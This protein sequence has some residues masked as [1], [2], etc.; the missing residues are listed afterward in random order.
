M[1]YQWIA[2]VECSSIVDAGWFWRVL[3]EGEVYAQGQHYDLAGAFREAQEAL[4]CG[5]R[6]EDD[7]ED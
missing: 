7:E 5:R 1:M 6:E 3:C 4:A 2:T